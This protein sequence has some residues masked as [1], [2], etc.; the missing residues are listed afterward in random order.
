LLLSSLQFLVSCP[1]T[2]S[3]LSLMVVVAFS[4]AERTCAEMEVLAWWTSFCSVGS[5]YEER[6]L[7]RSRCCTRRLTPHGHIILGPTTSTTKSTVDAL[8]S[9]ESSRRETRNTRFC[10]SE[11]ILGTSAH[12]QESV[13]SLFRLEVIRDLTSITAQYVVQ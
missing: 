11:K 10:T 9:K 6:R 12:V 8:L 1:P 13:F 3:S 2:S 5:K 4:K 7:I